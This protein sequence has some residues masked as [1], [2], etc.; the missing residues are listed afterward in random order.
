MDRCGNAEFF[1]QNAP[2]GAIGN[3]VIDKSLLENSK[4]QHHIKRSGAVF[5]VIIERQ[6]VF[7][8]YFIR[9]GSTA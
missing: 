8:A 3:C 5:S 6:G 4:K 9:P 7:P 1:T 2:Q